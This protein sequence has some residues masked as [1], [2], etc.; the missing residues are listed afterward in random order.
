[1]REGDV[2]AERADAV[3]AY[4]VGAGVDP[5][6]LTAVG[7]GEIRPIEENTTPQ[8]RAANRRIELKL[9]ER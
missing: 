8:G 5:V 9:T 4:L 2:R 3:V 1:M 7:Y 6:Q